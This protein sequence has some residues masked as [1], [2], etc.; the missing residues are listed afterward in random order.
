MKHQITITALLT[1]VLVSCASTKSQP[2][3]YTDVP[4]DS[5]KDLCL[6][7]MEN[8]APA[9]NIPQSAL[10]PYQDEETKLYGYAD[11]DG[12]VKIRAKYETAGDFFFVLRGKNEGKSYAAVK[13]RGKYGIIDEKGKTAI[14]FK[15]KGLRL[16]YADRGNVLVADGWR[17][18]TKFGLYRAGTAG[19]NGNI[20]RIGFGFYSDEEYLSFWNMT[21]GELVLNNV[22][23][24]Y[25]RSLL[26]SGQ[27]IYLE[28]LKDDFL[29]AFDSDGALRMYRFIRQSEDGTA[30]SVNLRW[31]GG[32]WDIWNCVKEKENA[33][34]TDG[35]ITQ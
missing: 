30:E 9:Q 29:V 21:S 1:T 17:G 5:L 33:E 11:S 26:F 35:G 22:K 20:P 3:A 19:G 13:K 25:S 31:N 24:E 10:H 4:I 15:Y 6:S 32:F 27:F 8:C 23:T 16:R 12:L 34:K 7:Y 14:P 2:F 28:G 18:N